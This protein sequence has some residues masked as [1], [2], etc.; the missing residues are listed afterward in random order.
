MKVS[1]FQDRLL[2]KTEFGLCNASLLL[3]EGYNLNIF[4]NLIRICINFSNFSFDI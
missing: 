4:A 2:H 1:Y 3:Y